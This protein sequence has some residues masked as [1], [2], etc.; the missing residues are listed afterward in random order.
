MACL[1]PYEPVNRLKPVAENLWIVDGPEVRMRYLGLR[2]PFTTRM[3]IIRLSDDRLWIHSPTEPTPE[4]RREVAALGRVAFLVSPNRLHT[5]WLAAWR[6]LWPDAA[7]VG[8]AGERP[9]DG[10]RL[11]GAIDLAGPGPFPW[12]GTIAQLLVRGGLFSEAVFFHRPSRTLIVTDLIENFELDRIAC[13][14]LRL[15]IRITGPLDPHGTAPPDMRL[16]FRRHRPA[17][18]AALARMQAW[19]PERIILAHG[20]W[21][22]A[23]GAD[24]LARAFRW[25]R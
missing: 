13:L 4:L 5:T 16:S 15:L 19:A 23:N 22:P 20:R 21:Y 9:W 8:V 24:E 3:T 17:L 25:V 7:A 6:A 10:S 18:R 11:E 14:W 12:S 2:L 1:R